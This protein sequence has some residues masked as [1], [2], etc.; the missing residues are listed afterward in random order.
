[1]EAF[2]LY[3]AEGMYMGHVVLRNDCSGVEEQLKPGVNG[4]QIIDGD[5][6]QFTDVIET[7]LNKAKTSDHALEQMGHASQKM[8][9][10]YAR[11]NY[12]GRLMELEHS[13][14]V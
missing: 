10:A 14:K 1:M 7:I 2:G 5:L 9:A 11:N 3:I 13:K 8:V 12:Y 6:Q 4:Y